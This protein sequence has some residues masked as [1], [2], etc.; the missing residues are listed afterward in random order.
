MSSRLRTLTR[1]N[2]ILLGCVVVLGVILAVRPDVTASID[3]DDLPEVF[4]GFASDQVRRIDLSRQGPDGPEALR[5]ELAAGGNA[6]EL[7]S[8]FRY[9]TQAGAQRLLDAIAAARSRG[10]VTRR[11]E[12]FDRYAGENGWT[13]VKLTDVQGRES[14]AFAIG[15]YAYPET[16]LRVGS[17]PDARVVKAL[18]ITPGVARTEARAWVETRLWP[19]LSSSNAVRIDVEQRPDQRTI[20][21]VKVDAKDAKKDGAKDGSKGAAA[22]GWRMESPTP[23]E[24]KTIAVEDLLRQ[25]TGILL[26]DIVAGDATGDVRK[27]FGLHEPELVVTLHHKTGAKVDQHV[28]LVGGK[29][30]GKDQWYVQ[31]Q[32]ARWVFTVGASS[33]SRMRQMPDTFRESAAPAAADP[34]GEPEQD[35]AKDPSKG[36]KDEPKKDAEAPKK[37]G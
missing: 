36:P 9:P 18:N 24:G 6:W 21:L 13:E 19:E 3:R 8:H 23:G 16:F 1:R 30:D 5:L 25:F 29:V 11:E 32:G 28:L 15:K 17:G 34:D 10:D 37:G 12:T 20:S 31:R 4:P 27:T 22:G 33:L 26:E 35:P 14:L 7:A 2:L